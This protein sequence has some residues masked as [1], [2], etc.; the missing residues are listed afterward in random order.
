MQILLQW[1][2]PDH[3]QFYIPG[4]TECR[5]AHCVYDSI[6]SCEF[7][8]LGRYTGPSLSSV[9]HFFTLGFLS[10]NEFTYVICDSKSEPWW[11]CVCGGSPSNESVQ[12]ASQWRSDTHSW[13]RAS[14][15]WFF[16]GLLDLYPT[17]TYSSRTERKNIF[18]MNQI[19][20][21]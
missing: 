5:K 16:L 9:T 11:S 20:K 18:M 17:N 10:C 6:C 8:T 3:P 15:T 21:C 13:A 2:L 1:L 4:H 7:G 12:M 19:L 14:Q